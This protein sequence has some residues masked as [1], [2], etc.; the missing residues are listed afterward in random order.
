M[1]AIAKTGPP[2][3][4]ELVDVDEPRV[5]P[6]EVLVEVKVC[7]L[8]GT[9]LHF[10]LSELGFERR[11]TFP[12]ILG[13]EPAGIVR[14]VGR[15]VD[16]FRV[17]DHVVGEPHGACGRCE[18][19]REGRPQFCE[20]I[21]V[22]GSQRDG[23]LAALVAAPAE[24]LRHVPPDLDFLLASLLEPLSVGV[25]A[26]ELSG[27]RPGEA[28]LVLGPGPI[29][30][31]TALAARAADAG[32]VVVTGLGIDRQRLEMAHRLGF[33]TVNV[34]ANSPIEQIW[35]LVGERGAPVVFDTTGAMPD[36]PRITRRGGRVVLIGWPR[37]A[38]SLE[39]LTE[40]FLRAI[41]L[42]PLRWRPE[43]IWPRVL[44]LVESGRI[45]PGPLVTHTL[46][47]DEGIH[48]FDLL[49]RREAMKVQLVP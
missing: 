27:L 21:P 43:A 28:A 6:G 47:L 20:R 30:L 32:T 37:R 22:L 35:G 33:P 38:L 3:G 39:E 25:H 7:G 2:P 49:V 10:Y 46:P 12:R 13:H 40:F 23:A 24:C 26:V 48:G 34:E 36:V 41:T 8:C 18:T 9:D 45:D 16:G 29:G 19:C 5:G 42:T 4:L 44:D 11:I 17:G 15:G 14:E 31:I 1:K